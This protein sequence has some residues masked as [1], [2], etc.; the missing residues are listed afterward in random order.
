M[1]AFTIFTISVGGGRMT[2]SRPRTI[3]GGIAPQP[4][5]FGASTPRIQHRQRGIVGN[6]F[7]RGWPRFRR[8]SRWNS[9]TRGRQNRA[10]DQLI[11]RLQPPAGASDPVTQGGTIQVDALAGKDLRLAIERKVVSI[12]VDQHVC[13]QRL[14]RQAAVD[15]PFRRG[16]LHDSAFACPAAIARAADHLNP[17]LRWNVIKHLGAVLADHMQGRTAAPAGLVGDIDHNLDPRQMFWQRTAIALRWL[18]NPFRGWLRCLDLR[19]LFG[20]R[21]LDVLDPLLQCFLAKTFR[22]AAE[23]VAQQNRDQHL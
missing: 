13:E 22:T 19:R 4:P 15:R 7:G 21:L 20:E 9:Q 23:A 14:G 17:K 10:Q 11:Q 6:H 1:L 18:R 12:F 3:V 16:R 5:G 2:R 8:Q